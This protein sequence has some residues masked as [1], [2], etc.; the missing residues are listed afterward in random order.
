MSGNRA[1]AFPPRS[2]G[3]IS[4]DDEPRPTAPN[5]KG[6]T[7]PDRNGEY[8]QDFV[9]LDDQPDVPPTLGR[10]PR[11]GVQFVGGKFLLSQ[12][13]SQAHWP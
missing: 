12:V 5:I 4:F 3:I 6:T 1:G 13:N 2:A 10:R 7:R 9:T 8:E 11:R